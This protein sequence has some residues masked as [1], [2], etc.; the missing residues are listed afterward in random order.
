MSSK[1]DRL[2]IA[3]PC[4]ARWEDMMGDDRI[5]FCDQCQLNVYNFSDLS[6]GE[7][8]SLIA[9][10]EG[11]LC[12]RLYQR[13]D[14]TLLTKD[15]PVGLAALRKR[16]SRKVAASFAAMVS[17]ASVAFGQQPVNKKKD[18]C[19]TQTKVTIT[20]STWDQAAAKIS[21]TVWDLAGAVVPNAQVELRKRESN[22]SFKAIT[23]SEGRFKVDSVL[24]GNYELRIGVTGF[25]LY[26][27]RLTIERNQLIQ[28]DAVMQPGSMMGEVVVL[29]ENPRFEI[30]PGTNIITEQMI[31][32][33][34]IN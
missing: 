29:E 32:K 20:Q 22:E 26:V 34:P 23:D 21:G 27:S 1:L 24:D 9:N 4:H 28:I 30:K 8:D 11:R 25:G 33:F 16:V 10:K 19:P 17:F 12:A 31:R 15:C 18:S 5:R 7:I 3:T 13:A 2:R 14:G 6:A